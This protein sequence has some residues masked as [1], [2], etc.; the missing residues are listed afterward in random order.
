MRRANEQATVQPLPR[1]DESSVVTSAPSPAEQP[2]Q[3]GQPNDSI[4]LL[5]TPRIVVDETGTMELRE[6]TA[7]TA[8]SFSR[9]GRV[10]NE[11]QAASDSGVADP[12]VRTKRSSSPLYSQA[13][14]QGDRQA[15]KVPQDNFGTILSAGVDPSGGAGLSGGGG[16]PGA[17]PSGKA[18]MAGMPGL[19]GMSGMSSGGAMTPGKTGMS[20]GAATTG[21]GMSASV[22]QGIP[23]G[24]RHPPR[25][26]QVRQFTST[27]I[28]SLSRTVLR[29]PLME[30][31][32]RGWDR[33][34]TGVASSRRWPNS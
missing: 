32:K 31:N 18:G 21:P 13:S 16:F 11:S 26:G 20:G 30:K 17:G 10:S 5:V 3:N 27:R 29:N 6:S 22:V 33:S 23:G 9:E 4:M 8:P 19:S 14:P 24:V 7:T 25:R 28:T 34:S 1:A 2:P 15:D 12:S